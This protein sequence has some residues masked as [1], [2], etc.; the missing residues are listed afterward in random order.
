MVY[1]RD[2]VMQQGRLWKFWGPVLLF[3]PGTVPACGGKVIWSEDGSGGSAAGTGLSAGVSDGAGGADVQGVGGRDA[4]DPAFQAAR[5]A[6]QVAIRSGVVQPTTDQI[7]VEEICS[8]C[9]EAILQ[10]AHDELHWCVPR[11]QEHTG[12]WGCEC[13]EGAYCIDQVRLARGLLALCAPR[14]LEESACALSQQFCEDYE[15]R[16]GCVCNLN[17]PRQPSDCGERTFSC[18]YGNMG[19]GCG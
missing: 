6:C 12:V 17:A 15:T 1:M 4:D 16:L 3:G 9:P 18:L 13:S 5:L 8:L 7:W 11:C 14:A 2:V 19:C 10:C